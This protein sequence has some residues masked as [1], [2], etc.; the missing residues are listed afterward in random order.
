MA[1]HE[2]ITTALDLLVYLCAPPH[3]WQRGTR[4]ARCWAVEIPPSCTV[5]RD[6]VQARTSLVRVDTPLRRHSRWAPERTCTPGSGLKRLLSRGLGS[7]TPVSGLHSQVRGPS[8]HPDIH[9][10][11]RR[12]GTDGDK[13]RLVIAPFTS[14]SGA[15]DRTDN[16]SSSGLSTHLRVIFALAHAER[17]TSARFCIRVVKSPGSPTTR[18]MVTVPKNPAHRFHAS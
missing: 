15:P 10:G 14:V 12:W 8:C 7:P 2:R 5:E 16:G 9:R 13:K 4:R 18:M 11:N 17:C 3:P 6:R 1:A